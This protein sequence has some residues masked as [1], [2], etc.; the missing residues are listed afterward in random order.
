M[1]ING[2]EHALP[3]MTKHAYETE[4][5]VTRAYCSKPVHNKVTTYRNGIK[6][7]KEQIPGHIRKQK[8]QARILYRSEI[9]YGSV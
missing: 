4:M 7:Y 6:T 3:Q 1:L 2:R 5:G 9:T 8:L